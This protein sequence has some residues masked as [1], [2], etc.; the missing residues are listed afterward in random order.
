M[1]NEYKKNRLICVSFTLYPG[2]YV[3]NLGVSGVVDARV[4]EQGEDWKERMTN[5]ERI[6]I[7]FSTRTELNAE[8]EN[9]CYHCC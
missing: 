4:A 1:G 2:L 7:S 3:F 6:G 9:E 5:L 8:G